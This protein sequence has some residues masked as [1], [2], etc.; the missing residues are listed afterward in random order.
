[1]LAAC[2]LIQCFALFSDALTFL[3]V[4]FAVTAA[5]V[6]KNEGIAGNTYKM[7]N[8]LIRINKKD[9]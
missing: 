5:D 8:N 2:S 1:M 3:V 6:K 9:I 4:A 7:K